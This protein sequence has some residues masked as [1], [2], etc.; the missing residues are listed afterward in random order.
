M[1]SPWRLGLLHH[2]SPECH[3]SAGLWPQSRSFVVHPLAV[4]TWTTLL[5]QGLLLADGRTWNFPV[6]IVMSSNSLW[7]TLH[8]FSVATLAGHCTGSEQPGHEW[9]LCWHCKWG[10]AHYAPT[11][12]SYFS[13]LNLILFSS[14]ASKDNHTVSSGNDS[15][16]EFHHGASFYSGWIQGEKWQLIFGC[17]P[18][19][20][21][22]II[23]SLTVI[24]C[25]G[26]E[27]HEF[28]S[29]SQ[30]FCVVVKSEIY[31]NI[32]WIV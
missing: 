16:K 20:M 13:I 26:S 9:V 25:Q 7:E 17:P 6:S 22:D 3:W 12:A 8:L 10:F 27:Y 19:S 1:R 4:W 18:E 23:F 32:W 29:G 30:I 31:R 5:I 21:P 15:C 24:Y 28:L 2:L 11:L 14:Q